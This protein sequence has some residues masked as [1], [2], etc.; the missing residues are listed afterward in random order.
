VEEKKS[1]DRVS[2]LCLIGL[3]K[4]ELA[5]SV[6]DSFSLRRYTGILAAG[7]ANP[8]R[9]GDPCPPLFTLIISLMSTSLFLHV[10]LD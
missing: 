2:L 5:S 7:E 4:K 1:I 6:P 3:G 8:I 10:F 9:I